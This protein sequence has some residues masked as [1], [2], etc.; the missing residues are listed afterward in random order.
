MGGEQ[1]AK[2]LVG[3]VHHFQLDDKREKGDN[4]A[5]IY[6]KSL[7]YL[8]SRSY[9]EK[10]AIV[11]LLGLRIYREAVQKRLAADGVSGRV[12][13]Y[14]PDGNPDWTKAD[15]H[16]G[17]DNDLTTMNSML[18]LVLGTDPGSKGFTKDDLGGY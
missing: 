3:A 17:F 15:S 6:R 7:L 2:R 16:G 14:D 13:F 18:G 11:P 10:D 1:G 9:Q 12:K 5:E 8:V 4:V